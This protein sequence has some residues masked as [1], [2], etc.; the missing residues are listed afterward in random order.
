MV[1]RRQFI[2]GVAT[3]SAAAVAGCSSVPFISSGPE[4]A[5]EE[6]FEAIQ[7]GDAEAVNEILHPEAPSYP[8]EESSV[9]ADIELIEANEVSTREVLEFWAEQ[10]GDSGDVTDESVQ[11][12]EEHTESRLDEYGADD[13]AWVL[14]TIEGGEGEQEASVE[15]IQDGEDWYC[16]T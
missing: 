13:H 15:A 4:N 5:Y 11:N 2:T 9:Q 7:N 10:S 3:A 1:N 14:I 16:Y 12:Q 6:Y 8:V